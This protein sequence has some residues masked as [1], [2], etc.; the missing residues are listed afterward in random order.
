VEDLQGGQ[1]AS[2]INDP[3]NP[4]KI[5]K[6]SNVPKRKKRLKKKDNKLSLRLSRTSGGDY[7]E[8]AGVNSILRL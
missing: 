8:T 4:I 6:K 3:R 1:R 2:L 7:K 5:D